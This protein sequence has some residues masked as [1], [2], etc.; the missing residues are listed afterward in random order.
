MFDKVAAL[1]YDAGQENSPTF[2]QVISLGRL[3][4]ADH[5]VNELLAALS[6][7]KPSEAA[8][9]ETATAAVSGSVGELVGALM[10]QLKSEIKSDLADELAEKLK[11]ELMKELTAS[12]PDAIRAGLLAE[13]EAAERETRL[14]MQGEAIQMIEEIG[15]TVRKIASNDDRKEVAF[16]LSG[17]ELTDD[18]LVHVRSVDQMIM[19]HL[20]GTQITDEGLVHLSGLPS[21]EKLHLE[22]T[23]LTDKGLAHLL[24]IPQLKWLNIYGTEVTDAGIEQLKEMKDLETLHLADQDHA[25]RIRK[26]KS[27]AARHGNHP[28]SGQRKT[29]RRRRGHSQGS[30]SQEKS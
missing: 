15:G 9:T 16:H 7:E 28:R 13:R 17:K 19:L 6:P 8:P 26:I 12:L 21:L 25:A 2:G 11:T 29:T 3:P 10:E 1:A 4:G 23:K 30:R 27:G 20:K 5:E 22:E 14:A 24:K 18:G